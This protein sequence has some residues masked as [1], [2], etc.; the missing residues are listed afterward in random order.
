MAL[1]STP[2]FGTRV[3]ATS[4][5][6][7]SSRALSLYNIHSQENFDGIYWREGNYDEKALAQLYKILRDR[8]SQ[9]QH[10][11]DP[12]L[13]D[14]LHKL[15]V[16]FG[17]DQPYHIICGYRSKKTNDMLVKKKAGVAKNSFHVKGKAVDIRLEKTPL[18]D[19]CEAARS[20][21]A[22]GVG[23]YPKSN[24]V[25]LDVRPKPAFWT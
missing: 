18:K 14:L 19:L 24:F 8:R 6:R 2:S 12:K 1:A 7:F 13:F 16:T 15:Q 17:R 21:K 4:R 3:F 10:V 20:L 22:G 11:I 23:Y 25:H 5:P 9:E